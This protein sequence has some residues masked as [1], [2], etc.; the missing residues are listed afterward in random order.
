MSSTHG[1]DLRSNG[2]NRTG[3]IR[4]LLNLWAILQLGQVQPRILIHFH[5]YRLILRHSEGDGRPRCSFFRLP[6]CS[7][8]A[9]FDVQ[10]DEKPALF[11]KKTTRATGNSKVIY[12]PYPRVM[13]ETKRIVRLETTFLRYLVHVRKMK[14]QVEVQRAD[15][16][17]FDK[18]A[19][20]LEQLG[21]SE[22]V[23]EELERRG[24]ITLERSCATCTNCWIP[25]KKAEQLADQLASRSFGDP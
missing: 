14:S 20:K 11:L 5:L 12:T 21:P 17:K 3:N 25:T 10:I 15:R 4:S 16:K 9:N 18:L 22:K 13:S 7:F 2:F 24:L 19:H 1:V 6:R 8:K 23:G